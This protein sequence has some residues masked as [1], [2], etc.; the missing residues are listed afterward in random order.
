MVVE[1]DTADA[2]GATLRQHLEQIGK[3]GPVIEPPDH[4]EHV[5]HWFWELSASRGGNGFAAMPVPHVEIEAWA[6][7]VGAEPDEWEI[8]ALRAMDAAFLAELAKRKG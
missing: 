4:A 1:Y 2:K 5:W 7:L 3:A 6:R 8:R